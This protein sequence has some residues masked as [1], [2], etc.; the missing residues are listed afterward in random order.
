MREK[1][2]WHIWI[3][4]LAVSLL[5]VALLSFAGVAQVGKEKKV[6][7]SFE[8]PVTEIVVL[9]GT[10]EADIPFPE[11]LKATMEGG[12]I[13]DIPVT[14]DTGTLYQG[15]VPG[16]YVVTA[17]I[18]S[19]IYGQAR[20]VAV[21]TVSP[22]DGAASGSRISGR[23]W[24]DENGNGIMEEFEE[25]IEGYGLSLYRADDRSSAV[26][27]TETLENGTYEFN[28]LEPGS[29]VV[30]INLEGEG[31]FLP[32]PE[33]A[34]DNKFEIVDSEDG[35]SGMYSEEII[36]REDEISLTENINAG[37]CRIQELYSISDNEFINLP[38]GG[39]RLNSSDRT[40]L[41]V[42]EADGDPTSGY[43]QSYTAD[44][45]GLRSA[46][47]ALYHRNQS[48]TDYIMYFGSDMNSLSGNLFN[49]SNSASGT[50]N[51]TFASLSGR[52]NTLVLTGNHAD[53]VTDTPALLAPADSRSIAV[54][55]TGER[56]F[57]SNIIL[58]NI[59]HKFNAGDIETQGVYM[60]GYSLILGGNSWQASSTR[61][62]GGGSTGTVVPKNDTA[63]ITV[64][65]TGTGS[66]T[67]IGGMRTGTL[68]GNA[69]VTIY[70]TSGNN[71]GIRGGGLG[72]S[73]S[74]PAEI[75]GN[76]TNTI[77]NMNSESGG[78]ERF[79]GGVEYG[80]VAGKITNEISGRGR[81]S[82][83]DSGYLWTA[84]TSRFIG[85]CLYGDVGSDLTLGGPVDTSS[86]SQLSESE[87]YVIKNIVDTSQYSNGRA[88]YTGTNYC[89]GI[90]K[91]NIINLVRAGKN[92]KG[93]LNVISGGAGHNAAIGGTWHN[94]FGINASTAK[95]TNVD[96]GLE[97]AKAASGYQLY[98][99]I[100]N[101]IYSGSICHNGDNNHWFRGA[102]W[103]Y[104]EGDVYSEIGTEG[105]V[106]LGGYDSYSYSTRD[107][108]QGYKTG[109]DL[110]GGGGNI[111]AGNSFCIKG[112]TTLVTRN[113][114]ARWT[115]GGSFG[116]VQSGDSLR[117]HYGGV[118][119]TCEGTG[120]NSYIHV[121]DG[122]AEVHGGQVDWFLS[123][124]GWN[125][126]YQDGN[127]SVEVFDKPDIYINAS[128]GGTYG[129]SV[130][131]YI[132]GNADVKV[133]GGNFSGTARTAVYRGFSA[134]PSHAGYIYGNASVT[135]DLRGNQYG[136]SIEPG[137]SIS[138]GRRLEA[139][140]SSYLGTNKDNTVTLNV[141]TDDSGT[142]LLNGL[143]IYGDCSLTPASAGNTRA[144]H[145]I[146]NVNAPNAKIGN[147]YATSY[148]NLSGN[149]L[150]RDVQVNLVS[151]GTIT[152]LCAGNGTEN[153]TNTA[154]LESA[155][156]GKSAIINVGPRAGDPEDI[157][158]D[159]E[160]G[161]TADGLPHR[162]LITSNGIV[163]F[164]AMDIQ[165]RLLVA[166][167]GNIRNGLNATVSNHGSSY[168]RFGDVTLH[169]GEGMESSG[170]GIASPDA[171]F[172][173][174]T[175]YVEGEGQ[176][177]VQSSGKAD[178][179]V[180]TDII[181]GEYNALTWLKVGNVSADTNLRT[182]WFGVNAGWRVITLNPDKEKARDRI[183]PVNFRG[184]EE[185]TGM[186]FIGDSD[187]HFAG[188]DG[189]AVAIPGT[190]YDWVVTEGYGKV[191]HNIPVS[192]SA[193]VSGQPVNAYGTVGAGVP[194]VRGSIALPS[195]LIPGTLP[196]PEF[197]FIP[198]ST[199]EEWVEGVD[200]YG[201]DRYLSQ[202]PHN[203]QIGTGA[204]GETKIWT[205]NDEDKIYS[206][207]IEARFAG[208]DAWV[209]ARDVIITESEA[210]ALNSAEEI[211]LYTQAQGSPL[212][213]N[214][215]T[216][217]VIG[218]IRAPL[219]Q[220]QVWRTHS[221]TY[222]AGNM[223]LT[224]SQAQNE[225]HVTVVRDGTVVSSDRQYGL[226]AKDAEMTLEEAWLVDSQ[227]D[228][229]SGYTYAVA[230]LAEGAAAVPAIDSQA[231]PAI[232]G[233]TA[234]T[235][236]K[237]VLVTYDYAPEGQA[238]TL[239]KPVIV[240][241]GGERV[242]NLSISKEVAGSFADKN[243]E[244]QFFLYFSDSAGVPLG[245]GTELIY[246]G[247][248][249]DG[250]QAQAPAGG[251]LILDGEGKAELRLKHGQEITVQVTQP[252]GSIRIAEAVDPMYIPSFTDSAVGNPEDG[253]D[254]GTVS[255]S[256]A[257]RAFRFTNTR[258][259][260]VPTGVLMGNIQGPVLVGISMLLSF[261]L[262][263]VVIVNYLRRKEK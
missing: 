68:D 209:S 25:G 86:L 143:N 146:I 48:D 12:I 168:H 57:G 27:D 56:Y 133:H 17:D 255:L 145:I 104:M 114:L 183:T 218:E 113:V 87:D 83:L 111:S 106:Y 37:L 228:L 121:G 229:D 162:I 186:T 119:D 91:G 92:G 135:I 178:Q 38:L 15:D 122:R 195:S 9:P 80:Y 185:S 139:G 66:S 124:G 71:V 39:N 237:N 41:V 109:F 21:I 248:V 132:S 67:F 188:N 3:S 94:T 249:L 97:A 180:F 53:P 131:H 182:N 204:V 2:N 96:A 193:P 227:L 157:L 226:Y 171:S 1:N 33:A 207:K 129:A 191:S 142:D 44:E 29:Y 208:R 112:D 136:F 54:S 128:M 215:I 258:R 244:F 28:S 47:L 50:G 263:S 46:L 213:R 240:R 115:Y 174:G 225:V 63:S 144:G 198:D 164:T 93:S 206:F 8:M 211:I 187:T 84:S 138:G 36:I 123:G 69:S 34:G 236:P 170:L 72:I 73:A 231:I 176:V 103:G 192:T 82:Y 260:V 58:R 199:A 22:L 62:F 85:G 230:V 181:T 10:E 232:T 35:V 43:Y 90:V 220:A 101:V 14:W 221:V 252:Q 247:G 24:L 88:A 125:D 179:I 259:E 241:I 105:L 137:D 205:A 262:V 76:V 126:T 99:N 16:T 98:G 120:Y 161:Q 253:G 11:T 189:Y 30:G 242:V 89:S 224:G 175:A 127:V 257:E 151:A 4:L 172:I 254:T 110:V 26:Q 74:N 149:I 177:Y 235:V 261:L 78:L 222:T 141:L 64:Y 13:A 130:S 210:E 212:F 245:A 197:S 95:I 163:G 148:P 42:M 200:I 233:S 246:T 59:K 79:L 140:T 5:F 196:Y 116:G 52:V 184:L 194:S 156:A 55:G 158:A 251:T 250:T 223:A 19:F 202:T 169:A 160:T 239:T 77:Y 147:L 20:P 75:T 238:E 61:Y 159:R 190:V 216:E 219:A 166:Q 51:V 256:G 134:G 60:N 155:A 31:Y 32:E 201:T 18:G 23:V 243:K 217:Q 100:T 214:N 45:N 102:G 165:K 7:E 173:A 154:A 70:D 49:N 150:R 65:S 234:E 6:I 153:F 108:T 167:N 152:G 118:V 117:I 107:N 81:F 203:Y 40:K